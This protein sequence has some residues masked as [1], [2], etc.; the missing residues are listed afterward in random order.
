M[1]QGLDDEGDLVVETGDLA[2]HVGKIGGGGE[3]EHFCAEGVFD[4]DADV[5]DG[6]LW[7]GVGLEFSVDAD[8]VG[9]L[10]GVEG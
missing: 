7:G 3:G 8:C 1:M 10:D 2:D 9:E 5:V 6:W 4:G